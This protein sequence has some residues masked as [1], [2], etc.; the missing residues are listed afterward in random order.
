MGDRTIFPM[1][2]EQNTHCINDNSVS[3]RTFAIAPVQDSQRVR[4]G[5]WNL[6]AHLMGDWDHAQD[7]VLVVDPQC[8]VIY[9]NAKARGLLVSQGTPVGRSVWHSFPAFRGT[10]AEHIIIDTLEVGRP[11]RA[12]EPVIG[13]GTAFEIDTCQIPGGAAI[14]LREAR[15]RQHAEMADAAVLDR[16]AGIRAD[17]LSSMNHEIRTPLNG[18]LGH[19][20][21]LLADRQL[22][23]QHRRHAERIRAAGSALLAVA[24]D[25]LNYAIVDAGPICFG[26]GAFDLRALLDGTAAIAKHQ[27]DLKGLA[28]ECQ[29]DSALP[30]RVI[31]DPDRI[32]Q[33]LVNLLGNALKF[34]VEGRVRVAGEL[35]ERSGDQVTL[36]FSVSDTG[37]GIP[38]A[39]QA[40]VFDRSQI[41]DAQIRK[42]FGGAGLGLP[43][44]KRIV[45]GMGGA[46]GL[47]SI[48]HLGSTIWFTVPLQIAA[49][50]AEPV[51]A[52]SVR[53]RNRPVRILLV[54]DNE[55]N[56][57][58]ARSILEA[59]GHEV[60]VASDGSLAVIAVQ[61]KVYDLVLMDVQMPIMDGVSATRVIRSLPGPECDVPILAVTAN[62]LPDQ[63]RS[64]KAAGMNDHMGKP[65]QQ[66]ELLTLVNRWA[67]DDINAVIHNLSGAARA[68]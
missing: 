35:L 45:E 53:K 57:E 50:A 52:G 66:E 29:V 62:V 67:F 30:L 4:E 60:D 9:A 54:E 33:V 10:E 31:G 34:T 5:V 3:A 13:F 26:S 68:L 61:S 19:A 20:D 37:I 15:I 12:R 51:D 43:V 7:G 41:P 40:R 14:F 44:S 11:N 48:V 55:I 17:F 25:V 28:F 1:I 65:F 39:V 21:A 27:A 23:A 6:A 32:R 22:P 42:Q 8:L 38:A 63:V 24:N 2:P 49:R 56:Q 16:A 36:R 47:D 46:I 59:A 64:F 58:I 18:I